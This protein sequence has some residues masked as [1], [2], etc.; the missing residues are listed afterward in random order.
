[1]GDGSIRKDY[2]G[3]DIFKYIMSLSVV[4]IHTGCFIGYPLHIVRGWPQWYLELAVPFFFIVSGYFVTS[5]LSQNH[6]IKAQQKILF[7]GAAHFFKLLVVWGVIYCT[8]VFFEGIKPSGIPAAL[9]TYF[10]EL[11]VN[12]FGLNAWIL[13]FLY[14]LVLTFFL[15]GVVLRIRFG[16]A[17]LFAF[18]LGIN[19]L[20]YLE[21]V[22]PNETSMLILRYFKDTVSGGFY[23]LV[24]MMIFRMREKFGSLK[25]YSL[26]LLLTSLLLYKFRLPFWELAGGCSVFLFAINLALP[27]KSYWLAIRHQSMWIFFIHMY[28]ARIIIFLFPQFFDYPHYYYDMAAMVVAAAAGALLTFMQDKAPFRWLKW[29]IK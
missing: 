18:L 9:G 16:V 26:P 22:Y 8:M 15:W 27:R 12:G 24:G 13:W 6:D 11:F 2:P 28:L 14:S 19:V 23:V 5:K 17:T 20:K 10:Y 21:G 3:I 29:L 4:L 7:I 1:M 25:L